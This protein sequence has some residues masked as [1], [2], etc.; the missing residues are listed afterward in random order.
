M[1][2]VITPVGNGLD[3]T[4]SRD[5]WKLIVSLP[6]TL[7][8][9]R[10]QCVYQMVASWMP[11]TKSEMT[12]IE[13]FRSSH[14]RTNF[15]HVNGLLFLSMSI[16]SWGQYSKSRATARISSAMRKAA[17][18]GVVC[19]Q[20]ETV[21]V[22]SYTFV[23][24]WRKQWLQSAGCAPGIYQTLGSIPALN[25]M[26]VAGVPITPALGSWRQKIRSSVPFL[27][28]QWVPGQTAL[29]ETVW[30]KKKKRIIVHIKRSGL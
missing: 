8:S 28:K 9:F 7:T 17:Q 19:A 29:Q 14:S 15:M 30:K 6:V 21:T 20:L 26:G 5:I 25:K 16:P 11:I 4:Y 10:F 24:V 22:Q 3:L 1:R 27:A 12:N 2:H 23:R 13:Y 18:N